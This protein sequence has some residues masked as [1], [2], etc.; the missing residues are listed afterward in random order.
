MVAGEPEYRTIRLDIEA[1]ALSGALAGRFTPAQ[2]ERLADAFTR[3]LHR[4]L[5]EH[6]LPANLDPGE[7]LAASLPP[8]PA[9]TSPARFG[10]ALA[11]SIHSG[12]VGGAPGNPA[13]G[14]GWAP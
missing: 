10:R 3:E 11:R 1:L 5:V 8:L 2:R 6:G 13:G 12:L 4:L 7:D 14:E 9:S